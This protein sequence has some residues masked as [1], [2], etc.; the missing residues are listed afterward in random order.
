MGGYSW[1]P[2]HPLAISFF[3]VF[4]GQLWI[5]HHGFVTI[6]FRNLPVKAT[7][8]YLRKFFLM[9]AKILPNKKV[10]RN[11]ELQS[12]TSKKHWFPSGPELQM[13]QTSA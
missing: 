13:L 6:S 5:D 7:C 10:G 4:L 9:L 8:I 1:Y 11:E 3:I 2:L 12:N